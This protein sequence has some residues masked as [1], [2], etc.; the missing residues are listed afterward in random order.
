MLADWQ[1][2]VS[3]AGFE[4]HE[5][6]LYLSYIVWSRVHGLV[7]LEIGHQQPTFIT[8]LGEVFRREIESMKQQYLD[9]EGS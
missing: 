5:E 3:Q 8:D 1:A 4:V 9:D 6:V 2:F 7:A